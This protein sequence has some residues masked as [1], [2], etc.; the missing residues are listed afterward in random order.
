MSNLR[1][2]VI[3]IKLLDEDDAGL[4]F[5]NMPN[6]AFMDIAAKYGE[7]YSPKSF[8]SLINNDDFDAVNCYI[9]I[10]ED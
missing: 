2:Y 6:H 5:G 7:V 3:N 9:R 10:I 8:E 4:D 1:F